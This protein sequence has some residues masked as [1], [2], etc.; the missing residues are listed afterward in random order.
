MPT[1]LV[2]AKKATHVCK[3]LY[4][5]RLISVVVPLPSRLRFAES[6]VTR[7]NKLAKPKS[8]LGKPTY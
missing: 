7:Y 6:N 5:P 2:S 8:K 1:M 4:Y 3:Y